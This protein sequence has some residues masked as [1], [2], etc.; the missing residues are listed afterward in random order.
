MA[1]GWKKPL[2]YFH[3]N[4]CHVIMWKWVFNMCACD[5]IPRLE[6]LSYVYG[7]VDCDECPCNYKSRDHCHVNVKIYSARL[8]LWENFHPHISWRGVPLQKFHLLSRLV[9][10]STPGRL[11]I[12]NFSNHKWQFFKCIYVCFL[13]QTGVHGLKWAFG[14]WITES[15]LF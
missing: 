1:Q 7:T 13:C 2:L 6:V 5:Q 8:F 3:L 4:R 9:R 12:T 10:V 11:P 14:G 15:R